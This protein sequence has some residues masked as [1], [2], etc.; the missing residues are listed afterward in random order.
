M[1]DGISWGRKWR[2][3]MGKPLANR[4]KET[5][6]TLI[7]VLSGVGR[8]ADPWHPISET[9]RCIAEVLG[10]EGYE[11]E[12]RPDHDPDAWSDLSGV[13]VLVVNSG[14][15]D[16]D[17]PPQRVAEWEPVYQA[18]DRFVAVGGPLLGVHSAANAFPEWPGWAEIIG[19]N[20]T[21]GVSGHPDASVSVFEAQPGAEGHPVFD[22]IE[23]LTGVVEREVPAVIAYDE[24]YWRMP[25]RPSI[26]PLLGHESPFGWHVMGWANGRRAMYDG[27]GHDARSYL[28]ASRCR[29]LTN[30]VAWL[31]D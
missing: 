1:H 6:V 9:S 19:T 18:I 20:W 27:L 17:V 5:H 16:P 26:T 10:A 23:P 4:S 7:T 14:G 24:R 30:E 8:Y 13:D 22:G 3:T 31:L 25:L 12:V 28:S 29:Y 11:V 21:R 2:T 15:G